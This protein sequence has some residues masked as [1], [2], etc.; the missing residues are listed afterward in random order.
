MRIEASADIE[1]LR[2]V[3]PDVH[4]DARG[5][6]V[7]T[8]ND[9]DYGFVDEKGTAIRFVEDDLSTSVQNVIRGLHGDDAT[10][11][12]VQCVYGS[13]YLV[14]IDMRRTSAGYL[15]WQS[16]QLDDQTRQQ[17]LIPAGCA[18]GIA[19]LSMTGVLA[20][21]QNQRYG[22]AV[23]QFTLRWDDPLLNINWPIHAPILSVRDATAALLDHDNP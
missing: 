17:V 12:L 23:R 11:K 18:T 19:C 9:A 10:W 22:G 1:G 2:I 6:F 5:S 16:F 21:K 8:W 4:R 15:R 7:C 3:T 14:V 20:Y 13:L